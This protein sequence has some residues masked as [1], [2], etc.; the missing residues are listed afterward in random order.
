M[1]DIE[2]R[3]A[4]LEEAV[5]GK[6]P[7][8]WDT[9]LE[10]VKQNWAGA[11]VTYDIAVSSILGDLGA[12]KRT[13]IPV[14]ARRSLLAQIVDIGRRLN[15]EIVTEPL[16]SSDGW[17]SVEGMLQA[18]I[19]LTDLGGDTVVLTHTASRYA[20]AWLIDTYMTEV[21]QQPSEG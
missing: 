20:Y 13:D 5:F 8:P 4:V 11:E 16:T 2:Q 6:K 19:P 7:Q 1:T 10:Q 9:L 17:Y 21:V 12:L 15:P 3:L 14:D 18:I